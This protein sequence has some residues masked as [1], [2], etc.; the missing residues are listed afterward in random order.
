MNQLHEL[1]GE[2]LLS[3]KHVQHCAI[4]RVKDA[5]LRASS[6][7]LTL[8]NDQI[9][10]FVMAVKDPAT[11]REE[12]LMY[13]GKKYKV[14]RADKQSVYA[15]YGKEGII[16]SITANLMILSIY[17]DSMHSSICVEATEKLGEYFREKDR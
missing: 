11:S 5:S 8:D 1:L 12:G 6:V 15:K 14:V 16:I 7:G 17:N 3:T 4:I 10:R 13:D 2:A 9:N